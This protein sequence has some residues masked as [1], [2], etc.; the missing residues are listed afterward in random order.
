MKKLILICL[1]LLSVKSFGQTKSEGFVQVLL[2]RLEFGIKAGANYSDFTDASFATDPLVG[3]HAGG[4]VAFKLGKNFSVQEDILFSAVGAKSNNN[5]FGK[6][7]IKL[8]YVSVPVLFRYKTN[9]GL[10]AE[11]GTQ[12]SFKVKEDVAGLA[13]GDFA[14]KL[15]FAATGG[16]GFQSKMGLGIGARY[17]YGLSKVGNFDASGSRNNFKNNNAQVSLFYTFK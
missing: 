10:Y 17:I 3:F 5:E 15:D 13:G 1:V 6:Q 16:I 9:F 7:D 12:A 8:Y 14:K 4:T 11:A 2:N